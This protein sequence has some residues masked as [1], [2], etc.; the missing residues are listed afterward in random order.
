MNHFLEALSTVCQKHMFEEKWLISPDKRTGNQ[1]L[2]TIT[3]NG[4]GVINTRVKTIKS[5]ALDIAAF[6]MTQRGVSLI[7]S[8]EAE[9]EIDRIWGNLKTVSENGYISKLKHDMDLS[10][11]I[12]TSIN[13]IRL[14]GLSGKQV[15]PEKFEIKTKGKE[16][17]AVLE[18]YLRA[19]GNKKKIDYAEVLRIAIEIVKKN[20]EDVF[21]GVVVL[22]QKDR[23]YQGLE[24]ELISILPNV[25]ELPGFIL[26]EEES[27]SHPPK[28]NL[29]LLRYLKAPADAP[30][31]FDDDTVNIFHSVGR[32]NEVREVIRRCLSL[33]VSFDQVELLHT[34]AEHYIPLIYEAIERLNSSNE[35]HKL[36]VTFAEGIPVS[37]S[38]PGRALRAW[39]QWIEQ[40]YPQKL[41][42]MMIKDGFLEIKEREESDYSYEMLARLLRTI[43][44]GLRKD[45]Y[46][47]T[48]QDKISSTRSDLDNKDLHR[49]IDDIEKWRAAAQRRL[50]GYELLYGFIKSLLDVSPSPG[51]N[52]SEILQKSIF[53]IEN[54]TLGSNELDNFARLRI[55]SDIKQLKNCLDGIDEKISMDIWGW[56]KTLSSE[57][58]VLG[59]RPLPGHLHI[60]NIHSGGNTGR[61]YTFIVG[62]DDTLFPGTIL[63]DPLILDEERKGLSSEMKLSTD[64][65]KNKLKSFLELVSRLSGT[66]TLSFPSHD[67]LEDREMFPS[68]ILI[69]V[70]RIISK[71]KEGNYED[72]MDRAGLPVSYVAREEGQSTD[73]IEWLLSNLLSKTKVKNALSILSEF[74]PHLSQGDEA[75]KQR[76]CAKLTPYDGYVPKA[77]EDNNPFDVTTGPI[78]SASRLEKTGACPLAFFFQYILDIEEPETLDIDPYKW[79][80][81]LSV[82]SLMHTVFELFYKELVKDNR[83]PTLADEKRLFEIL[84]EQIKEYLKEQP[85]PSENEF[86]KNED[87]PLC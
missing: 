2:E 3:R 16:L 30:E 81:Q 71:Q 62:M 31:P 63:Q 56:L 73:G 59:T 27:R 8:T 77:G 78:M 70:F 49:E 29:D 42:V 6:E 38:R 58:T 10:R 85:P 20:S 47:K 76:T 68:P 60:D 50:R 17:S 66:L 7:S 4:R 21:K 84:D 14:A 13:S 82:G 34:N 55:A 79:L 72:F 9:V 43:P 75:V 18:E 45:R 39:L 1:W 37:Y 23:D 40:D 46:L 74:Y 33:G 22:L 41:M 12:Y 83:V 44:I 19:I 24:K 15:S 57:I 64:R 25:A 28:S 48:I 11:A 35:A 65:I 26:D 69:D 67:L 52:G 80:D 86:G 87:S 5:M 32:M 61:P 36:Q 53:F 54:M 51:Q